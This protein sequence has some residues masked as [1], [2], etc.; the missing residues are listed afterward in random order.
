MKEACW[1][2]SNITAGTKEQ[3]NAVIQS[4]CIE[5]IVHLL[6]HGELEIKR[7]AA[8]AISNATSGGE[9]SQI[10]QLVQ[11]GCIG[12]LCELLRVMDQRVVQVRCLLSMFTPGMQRRSADHESTRC[13]DAYA[14]CKLVHRGCLAHRPLHE[15]R[16]SHQQTQKT[17]DMCIGWPQV[18]LEGL[19]NI[20]T[21]GERLKDMPG[22]SNQN[23]YG[24]LL[25]EA[26]GLDLL[27]NLQNHTTED[28]ANKAVDILQSFFEAATDDN[29][30]GMPAVGNAGMYNFGEPMAKDDSGGEA[31]FNFG[32]V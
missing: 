28:I 4:G 27:E 14:F 5:P 10:Q 11:Y 6:K 1:T 7:E 16:C 12:P 20:L 17:C 19:K 23:Q 30:Q 29:D 21:A 15:H 8:W 2:V 31:S 3:I 22:S 9:L 32:G 18:A 24:L 13:N 25:E 26:G